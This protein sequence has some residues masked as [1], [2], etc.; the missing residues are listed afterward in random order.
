MTERTP[1]IPR[2][3]L[4]Y[5][6]YLDW[7][8]LNKVFDSLDVYSQRGYALSTAQGAEMID[9]ARVSDGFYRT[10]VLVLC[11]VAIFTKAKICPKH[12]GL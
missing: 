1:D 4:S 6:D 11:S 2:A 7:N 8:K 3:T 12:L 9:G 10:L 5:P